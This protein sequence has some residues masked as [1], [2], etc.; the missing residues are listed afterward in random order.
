MDAVD[1]HT[2]TGNAFCAVLHTVD[3]H[4][5]DL[6]LTQWQSAGTSI[7]TQVIGKLVGHMLRPHSPEHSTVQA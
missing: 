7:N 4:H 6:S 2:L 1:A 5:A 3:L